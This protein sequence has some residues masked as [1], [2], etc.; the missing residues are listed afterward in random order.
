MNSIKNE[1]A[2]KILAIYAI[3]VLIVSFFTYFVKYNYPPAVFWDENYHIA[4]AQKY[5]D[6]VMFME[7]H[8]P[9]GKLFIALGEYVIQ[10]NKN[11]GI[12]KFTETDYIKDFPQGYSFAGVRFFPT[13]FAWMSALVF[14]FI[15]YF[16]SKNPH[17][18]AIF[19]S[20]Y[21]F[22]NAL[23]VH[24]R[25][26]MLEGSHLFFILL[27]ILYW[28]YLISK[29]DKIKNM[30]YFVLGLLVGL[31]VMVKATGA[32]TFL[33][34]LF[35]FAYDYRNEFKEYR[36]NISA[37]FKNFFVKS[38]LT[39]VGISAV[40]FPVW[41]IHFSLGKNVANDKFY[42]ASEEYKNIIANGGAANPLNFF[43]MLRD[44]LKYMAN[45]NNG[46][47]KLDVCKPDE[48]GSHPLV[49][50]VGD[51]SI[52]Y[53]WEK[54]GGGIRY[55]YLQSNP[56]IWLL[57]LLAV[58]LAIILIASKFVYNL[59]IKNKRL[60]YLIVSFA[61][62]YGSYMAAMLR[63]TR[64]MYLYHYFI[65]LIFSFI[66]LFLVF[67]YIFAEYLIKNKK[68]VY[69][70]ALAFLILIIASYQFYSPL[71]YY[72]PLTTKEFNKRIWF[73]FWKLKAIN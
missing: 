53:R 34:F 68:T 18:S 9:L 27:A 3:A 50:P 47:P 24:S 22:D 20:L 45:Y 16:L 37:L 25:S 36:K 64:V 5:L 61:V 62:M 1:G 69:A 48:N 26:A 63:I 42:S 31:S 39:V 10:P 60:F 72:K 51:K 58:I 49:W 71:T 33:L 43:T 70:L 13:L 54:S 73:D 6:G 2:K 21:V 32:I 35:L 65:P 28:S 12:H 41:Y 14:F 30:S 55:L 52:N 11:L 4:S 19:T 66:L 40:F 23:I 67:Q 57:S 46:V 17:L 7:P 56:T 38:I 44:N 59:E 29:K 8:P 15:L